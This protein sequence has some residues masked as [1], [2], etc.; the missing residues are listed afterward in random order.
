MFPSSGEGREEPTLLGP[1]ERPN[2]YHWRLHVKVKVKVKV[3][4]LPTVSLPVCLGARHPSGTRDQFFSFSVYLFLDSW[5]FVDVGRPLWGEVGFVVFSFCRASP[6]RPFSD[7]SSMGIISRF[8]CLYFWD[9][10]NFEG[11][12]PVFISPRN[13]TALLYPVPS[14]TSGNW[15]CLINLHITAWYIQYNTYIRPLLVQ[16]RYSRLYPIKG[17]SGRNTSLIT[18]TVI[19]LTTAKFKSLMRIHVIQQ[20]LYKHLTS[21]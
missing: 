12:D 13:R 5:G 17:S 19:C 2:L 11:Q 14:Y 16:V 1:L 20:Q 4:L 15:V 9:S 6:A 18:W 21:G 7:L 10:P 8:Y 3:I